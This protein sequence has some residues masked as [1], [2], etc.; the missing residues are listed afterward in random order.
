MTFSGCTGLC[1]RS[2]LQGIGVVAAGS[3]LGCGLSADEILDAMPASTCGTNMICLDLTLPLYK[4]LTGVG[5]SVKVG[6]PGDTLIVIR[7]TDTMTVALSDICPHA[8][9]GV[10]FD[11][12]S[13]LLICPCHGSQF[14]LSGAV[15]RGPAAKPLK[16]YASVL[17]PAA[18]LVTITLA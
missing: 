3:L 18:Q 9:C 6:V 1:R 5:G 2:L 17:D 8:R 4:P 7:T 15:V 14:K 10:R 12:Q 11:T 13:Q 16:L